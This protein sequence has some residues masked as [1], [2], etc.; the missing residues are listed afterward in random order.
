GRLAGR[1]PLDLADRLLERKALAGDVRFI[2]RRRHAAQLRHQRRPRALIERTS[3][4]AGILVETGNCT[5]NERVVVGHGSPAY[6]FGAPIA[7]MNSSVNSNVISSVNSNVISNLISNGFRFRTDCASKS[8]P[9]VPGWS[10]ARRP[11][12]QPV[13]QCDA[14]I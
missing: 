7:F 10:T 11:G 9:R 1:F 8:C 2:E 13:L 3:G 5:G 14:H 12:N 4:V 6:A